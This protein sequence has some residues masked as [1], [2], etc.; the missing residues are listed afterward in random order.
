VTSAATFDQKHCM[1]RFR[2]Q[3]LGFL[4][5]PQAS[6]VA[7]TGAVVPLVKF[8]F[9]AQHG[10]RTEEASPG[11]TQCTDQTAN[12]NDQERDLSRVDRR[13]THGV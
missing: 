3:M 5:S 1:V 8:I 4:H 6:A 12:R 7:Q 2:T 11:F 9:G 13:V 10:T